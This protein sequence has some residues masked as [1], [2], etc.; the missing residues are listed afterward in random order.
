MWEQ[1]QGP[2]LR[3]GSIGDSLEGV[4]GSELEIEKASHAQ[5]SMYKS[6][7]KHGVIEQPHWSLDGEDGRSL[8]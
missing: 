3:P 5:N 1:N 6:I 7:R 8:D 4:V 2:L